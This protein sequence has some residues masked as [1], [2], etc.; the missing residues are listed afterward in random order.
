MSPHYPPDPVL[1]TLRERG[2]GI[3]QVR[4]RA[5]RSVLLSVSRDGRVLNSHE[6]F[7]SAPRRVLEAIATCLAAP[8]GSLE[9]AAA[10]GTIRDWEGTHDGLALARRSPRRSPPRSSVDVTPLRAL[11]DRYNR[12]RFGGRLPS[13]PLRVSD[14]MTRALG[15]ISY[16]ESDGRRVHGIA[17]SADLLVAGDEGPVTNTLLHEMAH[18]EAWL[19]WGH[20]GHGAL[21]RRIAERVGCE[22]RA[23]SCHP[24]RGRGR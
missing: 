2:S 21:W 23:R 10:M 4:Y 13:I 1:A 15:T 7:R 11:F 14:R 16:D 5:N 3:I 6:C 9:R 24:V 8:R 22:A 20:R 17:L 19:E 18:A 12:E